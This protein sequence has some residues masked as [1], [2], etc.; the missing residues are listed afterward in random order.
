[1]HNNDLGNGVTTEMIFENYRKVLDKEFK[2]RCADIGGDINKLIECA[3]KL[4]IVE[5]TLKELRSNVCKENNI[6]SW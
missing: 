1:M 4:N 2:E 3:N 6:Q 5:S